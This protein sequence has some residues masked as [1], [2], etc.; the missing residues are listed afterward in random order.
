VERDVCDSDVVEVAER[1][2]ELE[3]CP[4]VLQH[5]QR[6]E[7]AYHLWAGSDKLHCD[8]VTFAVAEEDRL[9][10]EGI[11]RVSE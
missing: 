4:A 9:A 1:V 3:D 5:V 10:H 7:V 11:E 8:Q 2:E 6:R